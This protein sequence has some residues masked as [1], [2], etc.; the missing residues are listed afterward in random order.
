MMVHITKTHI[1]LCL[2][3]FHSTK[4]K[5]DF[6]I[7]IQHIKKVGKHS[8]PTAH[9]LTYTR[10]KFPANYYSSDKIMV[11]IT[12]THIVLCLMIFHSTKAKM[13]WYLDSAHQNSWKTLT[14]SNSYAHTHQKLISNQLYSIDKMMVQVT[15]LFYVWWSSTQPKQTWF[16]IWIQHIKT[17]GK[18]SLSVICMLTHIRN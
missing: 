15:I 17:V 11:H 9:M 1:V 13:I 18:H 10:N 12:K 16:D 8:I 6:N 14:F 5:N 7:W 2:M 4:M 3:M